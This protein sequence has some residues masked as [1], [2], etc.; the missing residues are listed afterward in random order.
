MAFIFIPFDRKLK[1]FF[2]IELNIISAILCA[3]G[4]KILQI[5]VQQDIY[6]EKYKGK[7]T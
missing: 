2:L 3:Y 6:L 1:D 4:S 5:P 7:K